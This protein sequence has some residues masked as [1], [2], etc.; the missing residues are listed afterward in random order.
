MAGENKQEHTS[1]WLQ[2][3]DHPYIEKRSGKMNA[4][5]DLRHD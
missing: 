5:L 3:S 2:I 1:H 4:L